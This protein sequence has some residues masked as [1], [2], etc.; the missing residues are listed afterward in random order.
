MLIC[1]TGVFEAGGVSPDLS[2]AF[3]IMLGDRRNI[4]ERAMAGP[5]GVEEDDEVAE[6]CD[7]KETSDVAD[8]ADAAEVERR[9]SG[10]GGTG[11]W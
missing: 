2:L 10:S 8:A 6:R 9:F 5:D 3:D 11:G 4:E 1:V 7:A